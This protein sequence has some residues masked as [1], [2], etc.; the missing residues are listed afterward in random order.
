MSENEFPSHRLKP[1]LWKA[2]GKEPAGASRVEMI[3]SSRR[4]LD[5]QND[6]KAAALWNREPVL[7]VG[8]RGAGKELAARALHSLSPRSR[9]KFLAVSMPAMHGDL[10]ADELFGHLRSA[11]TG[12]TDARSGAFAS[13]D[14]GTLFLDEIADM[15]LDTQAALLRVIDTGEVKAIG[16]DLP[17]HADVRIV[18]ATNQDLPA[19]V[20]QGRFRADLY[21][22]L[23][24][25]QIQVPPL[26]DRLEDLPALAAHFLRECCQNAG[27]ALKKRKAETCP[28]GA[29]VECAKDSFYSTLMN[30]HWPGNIRE[31]RLVVIEVR[32]RHLDAVLDDSH[33]TKFPGKEWAGDMSL[34][35]A[36]RRHITMVLH[37]KK[38]NLTQTA[39]A[40]GMPRSS[41]REKMKKLG[42]EI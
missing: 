2:A 41:L 38:G 7:L 39:R 24:V 40:L 15:R 13:A 6:L 27:C 29:K 3:G 8:E 23:R 31:L 30:Y 28:K 17:Q 35:S 11:F 14:K 22:R 36:M 42:I 32:S 9:Q 16:E 10:C 19:L 26:R 25:F 33:L 12:A 21:D 18:A 20:K 1:I 37:L 34:E 5:F 4:F